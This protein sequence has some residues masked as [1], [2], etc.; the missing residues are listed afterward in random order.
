VA[1]VFQTTYNFIVIVSDLEHTFVKKNHHK[2]GNKFLNVIQL[3]LEVAHMERVTDQTSSE[4]AM[5]NAAKMKRCIEI[6]WS[7][8]CVVFFT[9]CIYK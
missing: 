2:R 6:G 7:S 9:T 8:F 3:K 5:R 1:M 4:D